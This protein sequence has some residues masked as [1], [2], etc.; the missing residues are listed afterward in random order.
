VVTVDLSGF[1]ICVEQLVRAP[2]EAV[3]A[4]VADLPGMSARS[5]E[6]VTLAWDDDAQRTFTATN[7]RGGRTWTVTGHVVER[8]PPAVLRWTVSDPA[9][10]SSTWAYRLQVADGGTLVVHT[11]AHGPG[12]S[13]VR[14]QAESDPARGARVVAWRGEMLRGDMTASLRAVADQFR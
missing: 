3:W 1:S 7:T 12:S 8:V 10:P 11:F 4:V 5:P 2:A 6:V 13:L 14:Q 9:H